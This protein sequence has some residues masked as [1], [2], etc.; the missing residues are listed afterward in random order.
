MKKA[1]INR[2]FIGNIWLD[3]VSAGKVK[4]FSDEWWEALHPAL[5]TATKLNI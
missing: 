5:K 4:M 1:G 3:N 2:A